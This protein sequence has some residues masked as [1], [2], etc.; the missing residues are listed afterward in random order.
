MR[1]QKLENESDLHIAIYSD[2]AH[3]NL[4]NEGSQGSYVIFL[5]GR[6]RICSPL[7]WRS[8]SKHIRRIA[9]SFLAAETLTLSM[10]LMM[11]FI[12]GSCFQK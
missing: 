7:N 5:C 4:P 11:P 2:V 12:S 8:Q 1:S 3:G 9:C 6:N 10:P